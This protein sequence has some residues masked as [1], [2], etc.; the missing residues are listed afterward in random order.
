MNLV[1]RGWIY[2][3][4]KKSKTI[5][6][7]LIL[8]VV[9]S[10]LLLCGT[11]WNGTNETME[12]LRNTMGGYF[13]V[14]ANV[15]QGYFNYVTDDLAAEIMKNEEIKAFNGTD[16]VYA[17]VNDLDLEPGRF[18]MEG[19]EKAKLAR[20]I[21]TTSSEYNEYFSLG[22]L[23]LT[24]GNALMPG[25]T[26]KALISDILAERNQLRPGDIISLSMYEEDVSSR[27]EIN[28]TDAAGETNDADSASGQAGTPG[29]IL[30]EVAGIYSI[31][32]TQNE[33]TASTAE[34][35]IV[36]NFI[37]VN[38]ASVREM[39][40]NTRGKEVDTYSY[41]VTFYVK[42]PDKLDDIAGEI[43]QELNGEEDRYLITVNN[44]TYEQSAAVLQR[45]NSFMTAM[46]LVFFFVG[47]IILSL[48]LVLMMR[49]RIHE[50]GVLASMGYRKTNIIGQY[51]FENIII[52]A[53]AFCIALAVVSAA[54][55]GIGHIVN[56]NIQVT[57]T[58]KDTGNGNVFSGLINTE[59]YDAVPDEADI[60]LTVRIDPKSIFGILGVE[61]LIVILSTGISSVIVIR[62]KPK[63]IL[64]M[65]E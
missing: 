20:V 33:K 50:I 14:D 25:E 54:T 22:S 19:D 55:G 16:I 42:D 43:Q 63:S 45:L 36:E 32:N 3:R 5:V 29:N 56:E 4:R 2:L 18:T 49:D 44:K 26:G 51:L 40:L 38:T 61:M 48:L 58:E 9:T 21:G 11:I 7:L 53:G 24:E 15:D 13:K 64:S 62:M 31:E 41:G 65:I 60:E 28:T 59:S 57:E 10:L 8:S 46:I 39:V 6:L 34:C 17:L 47:F 12:D 35:D 27:T 52:A 1:K 23:K 30:T 37:F